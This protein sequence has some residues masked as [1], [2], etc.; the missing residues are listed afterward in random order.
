MARTLI[1][2]VQVTVAQKLFIKLAFK[3]SV[4][5]NIGHRRLVKPYWHESLCYSAA[6]FFRRKAG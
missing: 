3:D 6:P 5:D 1:I 2:S 4:A